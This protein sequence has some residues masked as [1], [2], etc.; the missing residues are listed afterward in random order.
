MG[1]VGLGRGALNYIPWATYNYM[2]DVDEIVTGA[3]ARAPS[4]A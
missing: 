1:L 4:P 2:A 3:A